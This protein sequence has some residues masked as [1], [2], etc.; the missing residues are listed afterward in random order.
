M[1]Y[2]AVT[3]ARTQAARKEIVSF[4]RDYFLPG[5]KRVTFWGPGSRAFVPVCVAITPFLIAQYT[6][7]LQLIPSTYFWFALSIGLV[8]S[9]Y[10]LVIGAIP[11]SYK[12]TQRG[13]KNNRKD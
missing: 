4:F 11:W 1:T 6:T 2:T 5:G 8:I 9:A 13:N 10:L 3:L 12:V 7:G